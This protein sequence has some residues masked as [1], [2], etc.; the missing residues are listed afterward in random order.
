VVFDCVEFSLAFRSADVVS[1]LA[2][3]AMELDFLGAPELAVALFA[4][5]R[6]RTGDD[7]PEALVKFYQSYRACVRAKV[8]LL[9][10]DQQRGDAAAHSRQRGRRYLQLAG[11]YANAF[12]RP[13]MFVMLGAT[14]SGKST[15]A[16]ALADTLGLEVL[17]TDA[18]RHE[19]AGGRAPDAAVG[20]GMYTEEMTRRTYDAVF[21]RAA[22]L[23]REAVSVV[24]DGTFRSVADRDRAVALALAYGAGVH[25]LF[26]QVPPDVARGR[27][28]GRLARGEDISD[29][30]P[31]LHEVHVRKLEAAADWSGPDVL[32]LDTTQ[33][34]PA[35]VQ[36]VIDRLRH[37]V[38]LPAA[39]ASGS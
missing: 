29:A 21:D 2:F 28:A 39:T 4:G 15:V 36:Q 16:D 32:P 22:G 37:T 19:L 12:Q 33:P 10:A 5:Y 18:I 20:E 9:R 3:L 35:L 1:E 6:R 38:A 7:A 24:L 25:F 23:L 26:C 13:Q 14:G 8:E 17:R 31:E 11:F 30:R 34:V 27:I